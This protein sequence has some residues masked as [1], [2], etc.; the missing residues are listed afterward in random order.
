MTDIPAGM[1]QLRFNYLKPDHAGNLA[2]DDMSVETGD[3]TTRILSGYDATPT[4][5]T[6]SMQVTGLP[7]DAIEISYY[8]VAR[9]ADGTMS[10]PSDPAHVKLGENSGI[11]DILTAGTD[12]RVTVADGMIHIDAPVGTHVAV[13][14]LSGR[15]IA[16]ATVGEGGSARIA[17]ATGFAIVRVGSDTHKVIV[18]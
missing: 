7:A 15:V 10:L 11:D 8:V 14:D 17:A 12:S 5:N 16:T 1:H 13:T 4:G 9:K 3:I 2:V 6:T 18:K